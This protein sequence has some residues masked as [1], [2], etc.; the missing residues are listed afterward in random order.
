MSRRVSRSSS[1]VVVLSRVGSY[2]SIHYYIIAIENG[3]NFLTFAF[4]RVRYSALFDYP[5]VLMVTAAPDNDGIISWSNIGSI[6]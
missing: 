3:I 1:F 5:C 2:M 4:G 6:G